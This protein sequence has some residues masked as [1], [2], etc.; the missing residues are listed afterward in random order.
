M[1]GDRRPG[2]R[3]SCWT[4]RSAS[5][6]PTSARDGTDALDA[7]ADEFGIHQRTLVTTEL[8]ANAPRPVLDSVSIWPADSVASRAAIDEFV[9]PPLPPTIGRYATPLPRPHV[10]VVPSNLV[11]RTD[12]AG[13]R[14]TSRKRTPSVRL[15]DSP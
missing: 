15:L 6:I 8:K 13:L 14:S 11:S 5:T 4:R 10:T 2:P 9:T 1:D 7:L 3:C 12:R